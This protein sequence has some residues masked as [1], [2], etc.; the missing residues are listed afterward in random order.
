MLSQAFLA[1]MREFD[2]DLQV[3][4]IVLKLFE[5]HVLAELE[6]IYEEANNLLVSTGVLPH[7]KYV[8][9]P[10]QPGDPAPA[11]EAKAAPAAAEAP[12]PPAPEFESRP[13]SEMAQ[14][15]PSCT[16]CCPRVARAPPRFPARSPATRRRARARTDRI[17]ASRPRASFSMP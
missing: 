7:L 3:K 8:V 15:V 11:E 9:P 2:V 17:R 1:G 12:A 14:L 4:L 10:R 6:S 13:E 5:R 16:P